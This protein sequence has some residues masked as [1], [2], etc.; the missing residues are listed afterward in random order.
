MTPS[1]LISKYDVAAPRYTSYPTV[2]YWNEGKPS[3]HNWRTAVQNAADNDPLSLYIH[4]L[5]CE[6]L[7]TYC[8]CNTRITTNHSVERPYIQRLLKEWMM[9]VDMLPRS[10]MIGELHLGGGTPTFFSPENL[11]LLLNG[12]RSSST[13]LPQAELSFE[14][15]PNSTTEAHLAALGEHGFRRLSLGVQDFDPVVQKLIHREQS[16]QQVRRI[17]E[18]AR[19]TGYTSVNFDLIYGLPSQTLPSI[20]KTIDQ[21]IDMRPD[22]IAFYSYAHVP[23]MRPGQRSYTDADLPSGENKRALY[24]QGR[25]QLQNAGY[26]E[27]GLDHFALPGDELLV[28]AEKKTLHRNF[29]GYTAK[30]SS[31]LVGLGVSAISDAGDMFVQNVKTLEEW[32]AMVDENQ[33]PFFRGHELSEEDIVLRKHILNVMCKGETDW[34]A[35]VLLYPVLK[36][37]HLRLQ[38]LARDG[39]IE[40]SE[41]KLR[42]RESGK[43]FLRN[44]GMCFDARYHSRKP[45]KQLFS[46]SA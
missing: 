37:V 7:C 17:T 5:F 23:W 28:A 30:Q 9:Y 10:P 32:N 14:A 19:A 22:R 29:M 13:I 20:R 31:R 11:D 18:M 2:P 12:I 25:E 35:D 46:Q 43:P 34:S 41:N 26:V 4:L 40:L 45:A 21:V 38:E 6:S 1:E 36:D 27:I 8:A 15:H 39:L 42:V 44:I 24:E 33:L 3:E 16:A